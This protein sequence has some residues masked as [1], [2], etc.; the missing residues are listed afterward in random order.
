MAREYIPESILRAARVLE[1]LATHKAPMRLSQ[2]SRSLSISKS[3]LLGV[4]SALEK[5]GWLE[6][7]SGSGA[8]RMGRGLLELSRRAFGDWDLPVLAKPLMEQLAE[9]VG[10]SVFLGV[11]QEEQVVIVACVE[12]KGQMRVTSPA[13]TRL[14]LLA[15]AIGKILLAFMEPQEALTFL[16]SHGLP[17]FTERSICEPKR[18][19]EEVEQAT[20][21]GYAIDDEEYLRGVRAVAAP[22]LRYG[23]AIGAIW[24]VGF[25]SSLPLSALHEAG[26]ELVRASALLS[27]MISSQV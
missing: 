2:I 13:G 6:R 18:F 12:G 11:L 7:E 16:Q 22:L 1:L 9:R 10:E 25:S 14:P 17:K 24:I 20:S 8:Y 23:Q 4:L 15:A 27:R 5:L 3:S 26:K 21:L 19:M